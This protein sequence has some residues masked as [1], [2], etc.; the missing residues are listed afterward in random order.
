MA[1]LPGGLG[2]QTEGRTFGGDS[3]TGWVFHR[4]YRDWHLWLRISLLANL[5]R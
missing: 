3:R 1:F 2:G 5:T 4:V